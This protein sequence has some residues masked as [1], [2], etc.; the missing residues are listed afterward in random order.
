MKTVSPHLMRTILS[1]AL[2]CCAILPAH[3][4]DVTWNNSGTDFNDNAN[5]VGGSAP[6]TSDRAIFS[7]GAAVQPNLSD[8][9]AIHGLTFSGTGA[10][11]Y[12]IS[13]ATG[14]LTLNSTNSGV[15][16]AINSEATSGT[17]TISANLIFGGA[18]GSMAS[19]NQVAGSILVLSGNISSINAIGG[20][21]LTGSGYTV[22]LSGSN[23]FTGSIV[24]VAGTMR[25]NLNNSWALSGG[26]LVLSSGPTIDNTSGAAITLNNNNIRATGGNLAFAG[27]YDLDFG[28]GVFFME[29]SSHGINVTNGTLTIGSINATNDAHIFTKNNGGTLAIRNAA[30]DGFT[31]GVN[32]ASGTLLIGDKAAL[33]TGRVSITSTG[34]NLAAWAD[35]SGGNALAN[36]FVVGQNFT[37]GGSNNLTLSGT[38]TNSG[39]NRTININ[40]T[41]ATEL[42]G[43]IY[44]SESSG[45]GRTFSI[46]GTQ[47]VT[48]SGSIANYNG[49]GTAGNLTISGSGARTISLKG[50]NSSYTGV[51]TL[52]GTAGAVLEVAKLANGGLNSSIGASTSD[53]ANL[54][55][56]NGATLR[57]IGTG[58]TTDRLF[59]LNGT[60]AGH[61]FTLEAS[62]S[63]AIQFT[64]TG[65]LGYGTANQTRT[66]NLGGTSADHNV[67]AAK[68]ENN[69]TAATSVVKNGMGA[70][71]LTGANTYTGAT[72]VNAG[73]LL[74][75]GSQV[76]TGAVTIKNGA[77]LGGGGTIAGNLSLESGAKLIFDLN[78][79][80]LIV[81]GSSVTFGGFS[82]SDVVGLDGSVATNTYTLIGGTAT[83][84]F[85]HVSNF[86]SNNAVSIGGGKSAYFESGSLNVV[87]VPEPATS[88]LLGIGGILAIIFALRRRPE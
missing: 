77:I 50:T 43:S 81:N 3:A 37:I 51:T 30:N 52:Q 70:W 64:N 32:F 23:S 47:S 87:V 88:G 27:T 8:N 18:D 61:A 75:E 63:G 53:K 60:V 14:N 40:N 68:I 7:G 16:S 49:S 29:N 13:G 15:N 22:T 59:T 66:L 65:S 12:T 20:I 54:V 74:I 10:S 62:G 56:P 84:D 55:L 38:I 33:G 21:N 80:S 41:G 46:G 31:G 78:A 58:D 36:D 44:L 26:D 24:T 76:G 86:G 1:V 48:V 4:A 83:F 19:I 72:T 35:L 17:N 9:A 11:G 25:L 39:G 34:A 57:Y 85:S 71:A 6:T 2:A 73:T 28:S 79:P 82:I 67:L 42:S 5:W 69:G 45:T